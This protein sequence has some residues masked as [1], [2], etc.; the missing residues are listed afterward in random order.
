LN[1]LL[2]YFVSLFADF[3]CFCSKGTFLSVYFFFAVEFSEVIK[4]TVLEVG[5][6]L[7]LTCKAVQPVKECQWKWRTLT[8]N[9]ETDLTVKTFPAFGNESRDCS[10]RLNNVLLEQEGFWT[11]GARNSEM[12]FTTAQPMKLSVHPPQ[13]GELRVENIFP[14]KMQAVLNYKNYS[15]CLIKYMLALAQIEQLCII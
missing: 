3:A 15:L 10:I 11:C 9:N 4:D 1:K 6:Q 7:L 13:Q 2:T 12:N 8:A 14:T 5:Q